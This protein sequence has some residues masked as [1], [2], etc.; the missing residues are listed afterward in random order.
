MILRERLFELTGEAKRR[1]DLIRHGKYNNQWTTN[2]LNGK[3]PSDPYRI[4]MPIP[5]TQ[6]DANPDLVQNAGY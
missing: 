2:M 3:L 5:Q 6:M 4:L 1:Q